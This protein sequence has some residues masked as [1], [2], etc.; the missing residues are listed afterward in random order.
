MKKEW[1]AIYW[2]AHKTYS[3]VL[4][5]WIRQCRKRLENWWLSGSEI[6]LV[7]IPYMFPPFHHTF[8]LVSPS[9]SLVSMSIFNVFP[10]CFFLCPILG[11]TI[12]QFVRKKFSEC[13]EPIFEVMSG[14]LREYLNNSSMSFLPK[15]LALYS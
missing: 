4:R 1:T 11:L 8:P 10:W 7:T 14:M 15:L 9:V 5:G 13:W 3:P 12:F 2:F 6:R